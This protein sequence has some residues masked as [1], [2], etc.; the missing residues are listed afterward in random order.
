MASRCVASWWHT[1]AASQ[2][3]KRRKLTVSKSILSKTDLKTKELTGVRKTHLNTQ[4]DSDSGHGNK[5][6]G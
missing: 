2:T 5:N 3:P 4:G 6:R 1:A